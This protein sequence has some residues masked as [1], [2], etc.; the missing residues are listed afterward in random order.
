MFNQAD[1]L[2][3]EKQMAYAKKFEAELSM[4]DR[5]KWFKHCFE[6]QEN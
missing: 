2:H 5:L 3:V 4:F 1:I 6:L